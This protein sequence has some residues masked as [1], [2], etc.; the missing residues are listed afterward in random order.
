MGVP[1]KKSSTT[2]R[3]RRWARYKLSETTLVEC[4]HCHKMILPHRVC[5]FCGYYDGRSVLPV[6]EKKEKT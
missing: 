1:K 5:P 6:K 4:S 3:D 2:R